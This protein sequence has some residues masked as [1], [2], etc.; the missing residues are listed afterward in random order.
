MV[1]PHRC[2]TRGLWGRWDGFTRIRSRRIGGDIV[3]PFEVGNRRW[4]R[5]YCTVHYRRVLRAQ[6]GLLR[7]LIRLGMLNGQRRWAHWSRACGRPTNV[8]VAMPPRRRFRNSVEVFCCLYFLNWKEETYLEWNVAYHPI[9]CQ[10]SK[11]R[12]DRLPT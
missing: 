6:R 5:F 9:R 12:E 3:R 8:W 2:R 1:L 10:W 4:V 11:I 7:R